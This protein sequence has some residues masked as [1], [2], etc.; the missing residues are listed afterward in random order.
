MNITNLRDS[1]LFIPFGEFRKETLAEVKYRLLDTIVSLIGGAISL[2]AEELDALCSVLDKSGAVRPVYPGGIGTSLDMAGFMNAFLLRCADWG[3]T[4]RRKDGVFGHPS[5]LVATILALSDTARFSGKKL[6]E[7]THFAYQFYAVFGENMKG[8][9]QP[10]DYTSALSLIVPVI[11]GL[12]FDDPPEKLQNALNFSAA[13]G[14]VLHQVRT[15]EVTDMKSGASAYATARGLWC[16]RLSKAVQA[17]GSMFEGRDGWYSTIAPLE[18]EAASPGDGKTYGTV[19]VKTFPCFHVAQSPVAC[20]MRINQQ[21]KNRIDEIRRIVIHVSETDAKRI[22]KSDQQRYPD[23]HSEADH[24]MRYCLG[25]ALNYGALTPLHYK[26]EFLLSEPTRRLIDLIEVRVLDSE[27]LQ[28]V[29]NRSDACLLEVALNTGD[30]LSEKAV[31]A[32]GSFE[33]LDSLERSVKLK[34]VV[35]KKCGMLEEACGI[36]LASLKEL[37]LSLES[38]DSVELVDVIQSSFPASAPAF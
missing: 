9:R 21:L 17:P 10:W 31:S 12:C 18:G 8:L 16:Y 37:V 38:H 13:G 20:A 2:P 5:D 7:L 25:T 14:A 33:G 29:G 30:V 36:E 15:Q 27:N 4:Y 34:G 24:H 35:E 26:N 11:A 3:D 19:E 1:G 22:I 23:S 6:I 32:E 28:A